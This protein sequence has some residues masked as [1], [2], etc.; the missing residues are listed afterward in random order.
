MKSRNLT[1]ILL[2]LLIVLTA[3]RSHCERKVT[4]RS[5]PV[6]PAVVGTNV[7]EP[8]HTPP[9]PTPI[10]PLVR[11]TESRL[12]LPAIFSHNMVLQ[13]GADVPVWGWANEGEV[14]T[15]SFRGQT[16]STTPRNGKWIAHLKNLK[17][18][19]AETLTVSGVKG[20]SF[21]N[22]VVGE[23]WVCSGQSNMEFP[24]LRTH[25]PDEAIGTSSNSFIRLFQVPHK[26][27]DEPL[28]DIVGDTQP[29]WQEAR[30][31][32]VRNF[33]GVAYYFGRE[34]HRK[35]GVPIGLIQTT[36]GG[37][38]AEV[39]MRE[40]VL[41]EN[42]RYKTEILD[43]YV[44]K[45]KE[46]QQAL[47]KLDKQQSELKQNGDTR[48]LPVPRAPWKP[49][50]LFNGMVSP[51]IPYG[52]KGVIWYQGESNANS[53]RTGQYMSLFPDLIRSWR[54]DWAQGD[55]PFLFVQLAPFKPIQ[56]NPGDSDWAELREAQ[57]QTLRKVSK[58]GMAVII[59]VGDEKD[60]HPTKKL[61]VGE[62]LS[63]WARAIAY[64][65]KI[66]P[67]GPLYKRSVIE[68]D[69]IIISFDHV[70][71]GLVAQGG[72]LK[73]FSIAGTDRKFLWARAEILPG[74]K[75]AVWSPNIKEP[76]AVRYGWADCPVINLWNR[77]GLPASPFRTDD[78][79][80]SPGQ[81]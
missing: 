34:L 20:I 15:V 73:G 32:T 19:R 27:S 59:D 9:E 25:E 57:L 80:F 68:G 72:A 40:G 65:E 61:E 69:K 22:V 53:G 16:V 46:Y 54:K 47:L 60:I 63:L 35:L 41:A 74:N 29:I 43:T 36:W 18:G 37:S 75:V 62:R 66:V 42:A 30:L 77:E 7:A 50:E 52:I 11:P 67:S 24:M 71:S 26:K 3:C 13:Q 70:G 10:V 55:F 38:P 51:L 5:T 81:P 4:E 17:P 56:R 21:T 1:F 45:E 12:R 79:P 58:T 28:T 14:V 8:V 2:A 33:S 48:K 49:T 31:D 6:A 64:G 44:Q 23:V 78:F 39:W 76:V